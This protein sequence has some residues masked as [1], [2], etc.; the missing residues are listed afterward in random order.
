MFQAIALV[1]TIIS[2]L[3]SL[4]LVGTRLKQKY[5]H[6]SLVVFLFYVAMYLL[7]ATPLSHLFTIFFGVGIVVCILDYFKGNKS[8]FQGFLAFV[9]F[10]VIFFALG[11]I[12]FTS[13]GFSTFLISLLF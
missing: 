11:L 2:F 8:F 7:T 5:S 6:D 1:T 4:Y 13:L 12:L 3:V 9:G 10:V